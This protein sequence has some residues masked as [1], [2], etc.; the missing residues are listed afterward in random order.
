[1]A[2]SFYTFGVP[3]GTC[4]RKKA[5]PPK[6]LKNKKTTKRLQM[7]LPPFRHFSFFSQSFLSKQ[8]GFERKTGTIL[9]K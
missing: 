2:G 7:G 8:K 5:F 6:A 3:L 9:S 1:M 4:C